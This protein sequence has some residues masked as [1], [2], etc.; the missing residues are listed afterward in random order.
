[1][2][3]KLPYP[4]GTAITEILMTGER[5][6]QQAKVLVSAMGIGFA[7]DFV[8]LTFTAW[9][10][11]FTT[12]L[13]RALDP[14]THK[15]KAVFAL[16]TSAAVLGLGYIIGVRYASII[17]AGS[18]LAY[19]VLVPLVAW[20]GAHVPGVARRRPRRR[21]PSWVPRTSSS[22]TC[23]SSASAASSWPGSSRSSRCHR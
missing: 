15:V 6:G 3:G 10:D 11:I 12:A 14:L 8:A 9:R 17:C 5:G 18:F 2:H 21:S 23:G 20:I 13:I 22:S 7:F 19:F 16:N 4:E 1:M